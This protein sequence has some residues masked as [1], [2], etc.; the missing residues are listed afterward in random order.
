MPPPSEAGLEVRALDM[1][2]WKEKNG[3]LFLVSDHML[4]IQWERWVLSNKKILSLK[5]CKRISRSKGEKSSFIVEKDSV[6][7]GKMG[8]RAAVCLGHSDFSHENWVCPQLL[9]YFNALHV[10]VSLRIWRKSFWYCFLIF[11]LPFYLK[12]HYMRFLLCFF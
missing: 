2:E 3:A 1:A 9:Y 6:I 5:N 10:Q 8:S 12:K 4:V 11:M 7:E